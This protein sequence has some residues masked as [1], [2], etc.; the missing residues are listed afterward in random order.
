MRRRRV[1]VEER[2][3]EAA[4]AADRAV[5]DSCVAVEHLAAKIVLAE[6]P[7]ESA[8]RCVAVLVVA[9]HLRE[10]EQGH[11]R[12]RVLVDGVDLVG[13]DDASALRVED[14]R[15]APVGALELE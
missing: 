7:V 11:R 9:G 3:V 8:D 15:P 2:T 10:L 14:P 1:R 6:D 5:E 4:L 13:L 12:H